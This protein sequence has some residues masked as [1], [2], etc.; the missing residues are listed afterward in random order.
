MLDNNYVRMF[1]KLTAFDAWYISSE[2]LKKL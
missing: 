1:K 2:A